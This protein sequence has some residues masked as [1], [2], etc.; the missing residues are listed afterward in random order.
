MAAN[1]KE[2]VVILPIV[3]ESES[4]DGDVLM[5]SP[6]PDEYA[7]NNSNY[8]I[9]LLGVSW[10]SYLQSTPPSRSDGFEAI[11]E[12]RVTDAGGNSKEGLTDRSTDLSNLRKVG[13]GSR[14]PHPLLEQLSELMKEIVKYKEELAM[15]GMDA[16]SLRSVSDLSLESQYSALQATMSSAGNSSQEA[17]LDSQLLEGVIRY[18]REVLTHLVQQG[19]TTAK[20][21]HF[22]QRTARKLNENHQKTLIEQ[23]NIQQ[24]IRD[25]K[26]KLE[27]E[28]VSV[29]ASMQL[30]S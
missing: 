2:V 9:D 13:E 27:A 15:Y 28:R 6:S 3:M 16:S 17:L 30:H 22:L 24:I 1:K 10:G 11:D 8:P 25:D 23:K 26:V 5:S 29:A 19:K 4:Q 14:E 18:T 20:Q 21:S 7:G 12:E